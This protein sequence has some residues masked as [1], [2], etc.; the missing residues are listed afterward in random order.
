MNT[1]EILIQLM[2]SNKQII[3]IT[4]QLS[5]GQKQ[6]FDGQKQ[7]FDGQKQLS[8]DLSAFKKEVNDRFEQV[9]K[10][11]DE[12]DKRADEHYNAI[13]QLLLNQEEMQKD[14]RDI[15]IRLETKFSKSLDLLSEMQLSN[16]ERLQNLEKSVQEIN[17]TLEIN[18]V[19]QSL[20]ENHLI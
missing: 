6:L 12:V 8:E 1:E 15:N 20:K 4:N 19:I 11:F 2:E 9:D 7:L 5:E 17:D 10:R 16:S 14:I 3:D 13:Y 18:E